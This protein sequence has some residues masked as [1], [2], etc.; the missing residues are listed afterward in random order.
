LL[1]VVKANT[2]SKFNI[3][4]WITKIFNRDKDVSL[5]ADKDGQI[6]D[7]SVIRACLLF[8]FEVSRIDEHI[9]IQESKAIVQQ[10]KITFSLSDEKILH[11][12]N[13]VIIQKEDEGRKNSAISL[14]NRTYSVNQRIFLLSELWK[15][16][17]ADQY[18]SGSEKDFLDH[19]VKEFE[20]T[21]NE[22]DQARFKAR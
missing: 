16:V 5:I 2:V 20:L 12:L 7:D 17:Y 18:V 22:G 13:D 14:I 11:L 9:D 3:I 19:L 4:S 1:E 21:S 10:I 6:V 8:F 15:I